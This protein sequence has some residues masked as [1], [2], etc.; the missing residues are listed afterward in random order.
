MVCYPQSKVTT[1]CA[2][3]ADVCQLLGTKC[4]SD[5]AAGILVTTL[6]HTLEPNQNAMSHYRVP[7]TASWVKDAKERCADAMCEQQM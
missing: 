4:P 1:L 2:Q 5:T 6:D 3:H 7:A